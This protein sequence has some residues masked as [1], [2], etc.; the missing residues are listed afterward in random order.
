M[1]RSDPSRGRNTRP[2][3][4]K[5]EG[6]GSRRLKMIQC[7]YELVCYGLCVKCYELIAVYGNFRYMVL[8]IYPA[9][10]GLQ[11]CLESKNIILYFRKKKPRDTINIFVQ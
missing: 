10:Q 5:K 2:E 4:V 9:L 11:K 3:G 8:N 1:S 7:M 6:Y